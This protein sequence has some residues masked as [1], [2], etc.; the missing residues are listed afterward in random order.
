MKLKSLFAL[1]TLLLSLEALAG[2]PLSFSSLEE[3]EEV[4]DVGEAK[5]EEERYARQKNQSVW[6][7]DKTGDKYYHPANLYT[8]WE[9]VSTQYP[10][11]SWRR[12]QE[13]LRSS[14]TFDPPSAYEAVFT[15]IPGRSYQ[16]S[17]DSELS[18]KMP[19]YKDRLPFLPSTE[20]LTD[21]V[22][23]SPF[24]LLRYTKKF[25]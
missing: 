25:R 3:D 14:L 21:K 12:S 2:A 17:F 22:L 18:G 1:F 23:Y 7:R 20:I 5:P 10:G 13:N 16:W 15:E 8:I 4:A 9:N 19:Y 24:G 6:A 11:G